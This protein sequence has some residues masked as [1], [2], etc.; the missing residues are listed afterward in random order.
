MVDGRALQRIATK[1]L[2]SKVLGIM[3]ICSAR[4]EA[5]AP[6][7]VLPAEFKVWREAIGPLKSA[8]QWRKKLQNPGA[9]EDEYKE[10][11]IDTMGAPLFSFLTDD[12]SWSDA[13]LQETPP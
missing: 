13:A 11:N 12:G 8:T 5:K 7:D 2:H 9:P 3:C 10:A 4:R 1:E 6:E